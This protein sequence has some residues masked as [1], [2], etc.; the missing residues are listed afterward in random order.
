M[1]VAHC[2]T[3]N[4]FGVRSNPV[5]VD[6]VPTEITDQFVN[7]TSGDTASTATNVVVRQCNV[8][9]HAALNSMCTDAS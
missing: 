3:A 5:C 2:P 7:L 8:C 4:E 9:M 1:C 6:S